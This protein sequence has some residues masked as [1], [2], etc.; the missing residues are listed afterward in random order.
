M[1]PAR[2]ALLSVSDKSGLADLGRGLH[3]LGIEILSTGGT[4]RHLEEAGVPVI[5]VADA[6]GSPEILDGRVKTLHPR[7][8]GGILADRGRAAHLAELQEHGIEPIDLVVVNLYPFQ[9]TVERKSATFEEIVEMIDIGGPCMLRA[10]AK[11]HQGVV[12]V[13]DPDD[14]PQ[15]LASLE[16]SDGAVPD[17]MRQR[18][19]LKAFRQTQA[20]DTAIANWLERQEEGGAEHGSVPREGVARVVSDQQHPSAGHALDAPGLDAEPVTVDERQPE[21]QRTGELRIEAEGVEAVLVEPC[22]NPRYA[23]VD[24]AGQRPQR[25]RQQP[26]PLPGVEASRDRYQG[27]VAHDSSVRRNASMASQPAAA[28]TASYTSGRVSF[29][30][31]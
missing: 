14:Y 2:R 29:M 19:A 12:V 13:V 1:L 25:R 5:P 30:K 16:A 7:I 4:R 17:A 31:A 18:L 6:T 8:H 27:G 22:R 3:A 26:T 10:A 15:V 24:V 9:Q 11:N 21:D 20:Y 28:A 23:L